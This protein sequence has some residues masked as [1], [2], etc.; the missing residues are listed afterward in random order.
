MSALITPGAD[1]LP[2]IDVAW[3]YRALQDWSASL[4]ERLSNL[5]GI[6]AQLHA[7]EAEVP[8][9]EPVLR[10]FRRILASAAATEAEKI[11]EAFA[12]VDVGFDVVYDLADAH[13]LDPDDFEHRDQP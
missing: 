11:A 4:D 8:D 9:E 10:E 3:E 5:E 12:V 7:W 1:G 6:S 2:G 13:G